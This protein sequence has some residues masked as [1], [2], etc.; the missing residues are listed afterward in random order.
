MCRLLGYCSRADASVMELIGEP[1][2]D[3][4]T[5]LSQWHADGWG[6]AAQDGAGLQVA[7]SPHR[8][9]DDPEYQRLA[10]ERLGD[11]GLVHLRWATPG[12]AVQDRNSHPF[13]RGGFALAHNG[14]IHPQSEL[15]G[16][17]PP[18]WERQLT[19]S[20][21]SERYFLHIMSGLDTHGGDVV[22]AVA[23]TVRHI[24][25]SYVPNSLN[26]ILLAPDALYAISW[27]DPE[28]IPYASIRERGSPEDPE[29]YFN[30]AYQQ[31][32]DA[33]VVASTGWPQDGWNVIPNGSVL[34]LDRGTLSTSVVALLPPVS[35]ALAAWLRRAALPRIRHD[36]AGRRRP[37]RRQPRRAPLARPLRARRRPR[38][39]PAAASGRTRRRRPA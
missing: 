5:F 14:A 21:D 13:T 33:V 23:D 6:M 26:A 35:P 19:G 25:G 10:K 24:T 20:T 11:T 39:A 29:G 38:P 22:A 32:A 36:Q 1:G 9:A 12:L 16:L 27:H 17:L 2:L 28:R 8:A 30:L 7:K 31:T 18:A 4:F 37:R 34:K 3:A 15:P